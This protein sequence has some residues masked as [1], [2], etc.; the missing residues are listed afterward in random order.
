M[1]GTRDN[2]F[3]RKYTRSEG[4]GTGFEWRGTDTRTRRRRVTGR[5]QDVVV[6]VTPPQV[7][8]LVARHALISPRP[9]TDTGHS[10]LVRVLFPKN[11][12]C[13][14]LTPCTWGKLSRKYLVRTGLYLTGKNSRFIVKDG[15]YPRFPRFD[16]SKEQQPTPKLSKKK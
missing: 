6:V 3:R 2:N 12:Q 15:F 4:L 10:R 7:G 5:P 16:V 11:H 13:H 9:Y 14:V 8:S 1:C